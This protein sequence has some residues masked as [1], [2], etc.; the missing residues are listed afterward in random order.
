[1]G[2]H[3]CRTPEAS[4]SIKTK[5]FDIKFAK[6]G[7]YGTG[8]YFAINSSYSVNGYDCQNS[9]GTRSMFVAKVLIGDPYF[10][11][12]HNR[13]YNSTNFVNYNGFVKPPIKNFNQD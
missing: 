10:T 9:D 4:E 12:K 11:S 3:G 7:A 6:A 2:F 1:M 13:H 8:N 5:G